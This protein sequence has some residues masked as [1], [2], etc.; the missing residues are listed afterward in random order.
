MKIISESGMDLAFI[1]FFCKVFFKILILEPS[2]N[3]ETKR[4]HDINCTAICLVS[5]FWL[6]IHFLLIWWITHFLFDVVPLEALLGAYSWLCTPDRSLGTTLSATG[7]IC[8]DCVQVGVVFL[9]IEK[10]FNEK[11][12]K[13]LNMGSVQ[14]K[15]IHRYNEW[16]V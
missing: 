5:H 12:T 7:W 3:P 16:R 13:S 15:R 9:L 8:V 6:E 11:K 4:V 10:N 2:E 1:F 14:K